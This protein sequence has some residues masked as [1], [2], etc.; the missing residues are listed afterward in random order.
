MPKIIFLVQS[1]FSNYYRDRFNISFFYK[2]KYKIKVI[3][4]SKICY[5]NYFKANKKK[6]IKNKEEILSFDNINTVFDKIKKD[7]RVL[8][9]IIPNL[10][11]KK[12]FELLEKKKIDY[13]IIDTGTI[14]LPHLTYKIFSIKYFLN[15]IKTIRSFYKILLSRKLIF[16]PNRIFYSGKYLYQKWKRLNKKTKLISIPSPDCDIFLKTIRKKNFNTKSKKLA[17]FIAGSH[18]HPDI[19]FYRPSVIQYKLPTIIQY[20]KPINKFLEKFEN[21]SGLKIIVSSHPKLPPNKLYLKKKSIVGKTIE[22]IKNSS[23]VIA[24]NSTAIGYAILLRKPI[25]FITNEY[26]IPVVKKNISFLAEYFKKKPFNVNKDIL[27]NI[28]LKKEM[29][30]DMKIYKKYKT[31]YISHL[32]KKT[33]SF[34]IIERNLFN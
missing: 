23:I 17:V 31:D 3:N 13:S 6:I 4:T 27:S 26:Y 14:P 29:K 19:K 2:K 18:N 1:I 8:S 11:N 33:P 21:L 24:T 5:S 25:L 32:N 12:I 10:Q 15:P 16:N 30:I 9:L 7:D 22:L 28:R 34:E 20:Y